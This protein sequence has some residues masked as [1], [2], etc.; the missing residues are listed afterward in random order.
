[1]ARKNRNERWKATLIFLFVFA[2]YFVTRSAS[3]DEW[4][5]YQFAM[6]VREFDLWKHQ[7]HPPGYPLYVF[8]G[9][10]GY[11][12]FHADPGFS[13]QLASCTGGAIFV[14]AWFLIIR[15]QFNE[16]FAWLVAACLALTPIVWMTSTKVLSDS[17]ATA[18]LSLELLCALRYRSRGKL[19]DLLG[20]SL[21]GAAAAGVRPQL[22][23]VVFVILFV[24]LRQRRVPTRTWIIGIGTLLIA[25][26]CWLL[27]MW[28]VQAKLSPDLPVWSVYPKQLLQQW[29]WRLDRPKV[30]IGAHGFNARYLGLKFVTHFFGFFGLGLGFIYSIVTLVAGTLLASAGVINYFRTLT[31]EDR[32]FWKTHRVWPAIYVLIIFCCLPP[33]QRYYLIVMPL[34]LVVLLRGLLR[35]PRYWN[36]TAIAFFV[37][38]ASIS[39]PLALES[40]SQEAP[41]R[42]FVRYLEGTYP[43][44]ERPD[45]LLLL[46]ECTRPVQWYAPQFKIIR[47]VD[48]LTSISSDNFEGAKAIYTDYPNLPLPP[49]WRLNRLTLFHRSILIDPK[50]RDIGVY[51]VERTVF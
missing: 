15:Q 45:V 41:V 7:P 21:F 35:L 31:D 8:F 10:I 6:G 40:H 20:A 23:A 5:S 26:L 14:A 43:A 32:T 4:D 30:F 18:L 12:F 47:D 27:P 37:L 42:K 11:H 50:H 16:R 28:F 13:L 2:L 33:Y 44:A 36:A 29:S 17:P 1:M 19:P 38:L 49:G 46:S 39:I 51:K 9:W 25:C 24:A 48:D 22:I 3:L 34:L